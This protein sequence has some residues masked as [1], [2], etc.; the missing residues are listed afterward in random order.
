MSKELHNTETTLQIKHVSLTPYVVGFVLS[1]VFTFIPYYLVVNKTLAGDMLLAA[2][3]G[4]AMLQLVV[5]VVFFLHLG[6]EKKP[7]FNLIFLIATIATIMGIVAASIW[8]MDHLHY[9]MSPTDV[10]N[11][12]VSDEAIHQIDG[13]QIGTCPGVGVNHKIELRNNTAS[14]LHIDAK[15]CDTITISNRGDATR[16][17]RFGTLEER[18]TYAGEAGETIRPRRNKIFTLTEL[19]THQFYDPI[20]DE[21]SGEFTVIR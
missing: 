15:L 8:I 2:I 10:T 6:R 16:E 14:P 19:G 11:K 20:N 3:L 12:V 18:Q 4:F 17:I 7:H 13:D 1:L 9:N 21:V 5:Q